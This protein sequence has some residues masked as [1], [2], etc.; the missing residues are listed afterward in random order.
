[1]FYLNFRCHFWSKHFWFDMVLTW[2]RNSEITFLRQQ[3]NAKR[4]RLHHEDGAKHEKAS[5][6]QSLH[7]TLGLASHTLFESNHGKDPRPSQ[8]N[9][10]HC[11]LLCH[12]NATN[13]TVSFGALLA[14][15]L[16]GIQPQYRRIYTSLYIFNILIWKK[17]ELTTNHIT[18][19]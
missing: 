18:G 16:E 1:M 10:P 9:T 13:R 11:W 2:Q 5:D 14:T 19:F 6:A 15:A 8:L 7:L 12:L 4:L 3:Q 17:Q